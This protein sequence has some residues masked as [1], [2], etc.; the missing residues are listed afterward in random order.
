MLYLRKTDLLLRNIL[1]Q[2]EAE[3]NAEFYQ[4]RI[5]V[6]KCGSI[7]LYYYFYFYIKMLIQ[8]MFL[9]LTGIGFSMKM[10]KIDTS[11]SF[12]IRPFYLENINNKNNNIFKASLMP[13]F[14]GNMRL[15]IKQNG[16]LFSVLL[17]RLIMFTA[18]E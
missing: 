3:Y 9:L 8:Q 18:M 1:I 2:L 16:K 12:T 6:I 10:R 5:S 7:F 13:F 4:L 11:Q 15:Q 17:N 14:S